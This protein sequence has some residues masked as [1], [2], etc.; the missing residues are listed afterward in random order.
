[1]KKI[2]KIVVSM[3]LFTLLTINISA[4][5]VTLFEYTPNT[6]VW[7]Y[8]GDGLL[9]DQYDGYAR[10]RGADWRKVGNIWNYYTWTRITF[11]VQGDIS[12]AT[13]YS[14]GQSNTT[15]VQRTVTAKDKWNFGPKTKALYNYGMSQV[16]GGV[17]P[18]SENPLD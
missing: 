2:S 12:S 1:M 8:H 7:Y 15:A 4:G 16:T 11:D 14:G 9:A 18:D 10:V 17:Y 5:W 6:R 13:A 3:L